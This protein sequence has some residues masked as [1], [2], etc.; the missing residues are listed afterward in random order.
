MALHVKAF[1]TWVDDVLS[2]YNGTNHRGPRLEYISG[3]IYPSLIFPTGKTTY[4][5]F[6]SPFENSAAMV[7]RKGFSI[8][9]KTY[10]K[11]VR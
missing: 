11:Q 9:V 5:T 2:I 3:D 7:V 6:E 1:T 8:L 10:G 4:L